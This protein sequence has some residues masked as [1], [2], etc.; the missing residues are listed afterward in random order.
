MPQVKLRTQQAAGSLVL[1]AVFVSRTCA[2][3]VTTPTS[4]V[5][6]M[7]VI[8]YSNSPV[9]LLSGNTSITNQYSSLGVVHD[10][11]TTTPPGPPG[12]SSPSGLPGLE[13][14]AG[15]PDPF[16]PVTIT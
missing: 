13:S 11:S 10:G 1:L 3:P 9:G 8:N 14:N 12:M 15:D 7:R 2:I 4:F 16:L 6:P 5:G